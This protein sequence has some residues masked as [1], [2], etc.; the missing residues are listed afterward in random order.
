MVRKSKATT[1]V[2]LVGKITTSK[3][4][5]SKARRTVLIVSKL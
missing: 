1:T 2:S 3:S 5:E 4:S